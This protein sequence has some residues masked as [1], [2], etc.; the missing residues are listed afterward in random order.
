MCVHACLSVRLS[1]YPS[2][3]SMRVCMRV[4]MR[5]FVHGH[6]MQWFVESISCRNIADLIP[7]EYDLTRLPSPSVSLDGYQQ[8]NGYL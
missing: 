7:A 8:P 6:M 3:Q 1:A 2:V 4:C 5:V